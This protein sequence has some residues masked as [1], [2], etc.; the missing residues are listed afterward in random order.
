MIDQL[1]G[2][3]RIKYS[4]LEFHET[5]KTESLSTICQ[6][7]W[8]GDV[9]IHTC[10]PQDDEDVHSW[11]EDVRTLTNIRHENVV[12]Y[13]GACVEPPR[14]AIITSPIKVI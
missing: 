4:E 6:G 8:H 2:E 14:F 1:L 7:R 12:L 9:V 5:T 11:L 13:M 10:Q 3:F